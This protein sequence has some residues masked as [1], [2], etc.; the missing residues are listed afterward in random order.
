MKEKKRLFS[1]LL[2]VAPAGYILC[3]ILYQLLFYQDLKWE[4]LL[5]F[6][7][8]AYVFM[9]IFVGILKIVGDKK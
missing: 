8:F 2:F 4:E 6:G 5:V 9:A 3:F 1:L 7:I